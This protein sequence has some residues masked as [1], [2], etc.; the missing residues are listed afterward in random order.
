ESNPITIS[1][2]SVDPDVSI[3]ASTTSICDG[4]SV[5]FTATPING[6]SNPSYQWQVNGVDK[7]TDSDKFTTSTLKDGDV[8]TVIMTSDLACVSTP[9]A[10]S[11]PI[12]ISSSSVDPDVSISASTTSICD[13][14]SVTFSAH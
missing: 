11:N 10:E 4:T 9:T 14:T 12:T 3:S 6:G 2:S 5:T 1:S 7:G 8:F 13:G